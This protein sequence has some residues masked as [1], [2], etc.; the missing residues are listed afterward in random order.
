MTLTIG[1]LSPEAEE[2]LKS[3]A[4]RAGVDQAEYARRLIEQGLRRG[5]KPDALADQA[6]LDLLARWDAEDETTDP[7]ELSRRQRDWEEFRKSMNE[8][9]LSNRAVY[10]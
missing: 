8:H 1:N 4:A 10:P 9:S 5:T 6:T 3:E 2:L 7:A